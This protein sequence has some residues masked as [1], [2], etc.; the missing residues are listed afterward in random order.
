[1]RVLVTGGTGFIGSNIVE[2]LLAR[3]DEV[4]IT[5]HDAEQRPKGFTG[6]LLQPSFIG[7]DWE[8]IGALDIL[9]H[10]AAINDTQSLD[11]REMM[12]VNV[13][14]SHAL[15]EYAIK[16]GCKKIVY[17]S[18]TAVYGDGPTPYHEDQ[19]LRPLT[20]YARSKIE[21]ENMTIELASEHKNV[22]FVGLRYCN[23]YGPGESHKSQRASM[24]Y[25]IAQ[26][27]KKGNPRLFEH[28]EQKRDYVYVADVVRANLL[29]LEAKGSMLVNCGSGMAT[30]FN[31]IVA[32]LNET[33]ALSRKPDY[34]PNPFAA[35][36]QNHTEC[37]ISLAKR[38]LDF[39]SE[40]EMKKGIAEYK[41][42]GQL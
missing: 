5:G 18:S 22:V 17:A 29:A 28:G 2:A 36:Y 23:V 37:D 7:L 10:E 32:M 20:P 12:L 25:Q 15:F 41:K 13:D 9:F 8:S 42:S 35:T 30:S 33:L 39:V 24:I 26:Q 31:D 34:F 11:E 21:M 1:M 19:E 6:K 4:L 16:N 27:M 3:G 14:A 40:Y 38:N